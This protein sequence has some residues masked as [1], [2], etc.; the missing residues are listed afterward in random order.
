MRALSNVEI[1]DL[2]S[3]DRE[4]QALVN[5]HELAVRNRGWVQG[6]TDYGIPAWGVATLDVVY[7][8][9][10]VFPDAAGRL[11]FV[12]NVPDQIAAAVAAPAYE[13][14]LMLWDT[15]WRPWLAG[16]DDS[17][18]WIRTV[19]VLLVLLGAVLIVRDLVR[20]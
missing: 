19:L 11:W 7:G 15:V 8:N 1:F 3:R 9:T 2:L 5:A 10:V 20:G 16:V 13:S 4:L 12:A 18:R 14:P 6:V 17:A